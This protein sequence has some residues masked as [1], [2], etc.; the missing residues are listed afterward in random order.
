LEICPVR[1]ALIHSDRQMDIMKVTG[2]FLD[3]WTLL[4]EGFHFLY[5]MIWLEVTVNVVYLYTI[6]P[7]YH[8]LEKYSF[9]QSFMTDNLWI[10]NLLVFKLRD[11]SLSP[12]IGLQIYFIYS[13]S[14]AEIKSAPKY[15]FYFTGHNGRVQVTMDST[16]SYTKMFKSMSQ[17]RL[18]L[19]S[20]VS[21]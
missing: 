11:Q 17:L 21:V 13:W 5:G 16:S 14:L 10:I 7:D 12:V 18:M 4:K 3:K 6:C 19:L 8:I 2:N 9:N 20:L 15:P 1:A